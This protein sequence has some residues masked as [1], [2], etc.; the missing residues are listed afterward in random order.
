MPDDITSLEKL[1]FD[2]LRSFCRIVAAGSAAAAAERNII[3]P[4]QLSRQIKDLESALGVKLFIREG[5]RL[6][7][8]SSGTQLA[9]VTNAYFGALGELRERDGVDFRPISMAASD[10]V[11]RWIV[12]P[13]L[14]EVLATA[15]AQ[16][17]VSTHRSAE[18]VDR[19]V[20]GDLDVGI[21]RADAGGDELERLA[22][23][24]MRYSLLVPRALLPGKSAAGI[25][26]VGSLPF[27]MINGDPQFSRATELVAE[28]NGFQLQV[29][30]KVETFGLAI[31]AARILEAAVFVPSLAEKEFSM[32]QFAAVEL[33]EMTLLERPLVVAFGKK[34]AELNTKAKRFAQRLSRVFE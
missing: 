6:K 14:Q 34:T 13:R 12:L 25:H 16:V 8:T 17:E 32:D 33:D 27:V 11:L 2:R 20:S 10:S 29:R 26:S 28:K 3:S 15:Q 5:R 18:I 4:S 24:A 7:L 31:E 1:S 22:F 21:L 19:L 9:A 23:P 30:V